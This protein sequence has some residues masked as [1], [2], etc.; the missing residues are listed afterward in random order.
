M[1]VFAKLAEEN[2]IGKGDE[3]MSPR[4]LN[5]ITFPTG[6]A[7]VILIVFVFFVTSEAYSKDFCTFLRV[8]GQVFHL[9]ENKPP[10]MP[11]KIQEGA[12]EGDGV[13][14]KVASRTHLCLIDTSDLFIAPKSEVV[15]E[16]YLLDPPKS[17][18]TVVT[19]VTKGLIHMVVNFL[20]KANPPKFFIKTENSISAIRGTNVYVLI[21]KNFTDVFVKTGHIRVGAIQNKRAENTLPRLVEKQMEICAGGGGGAGAAVLKGAEKIG[22]DTILGPQKAIRIFEGISASFSKKV[23][24]PL[25]YFDRLDKLMITGLPDQF[26]EGKDPKQLLDLIGLL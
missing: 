24:V 3:K 23:S 7:F 11:A 26:Q 1:P 8:I 18:E 22:H 9:K 6:K 20:D 21:G 17:K 13:H 16:S 14:T 2:I 4:N 5:F 10:G 12:S 19:L 25:E 15:M